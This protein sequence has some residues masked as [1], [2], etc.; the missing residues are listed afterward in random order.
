MCN[1]G[2]PCGRTLLVLVLNVE[3]PDVRSSCWSPLCIIFWCYTVVFLVTKHKDIS[4]HTDWVIWILKSRNAFTFY[5]HSR[6]LVQMHYRFLVNAFTTF[7]SY[8]PLSP[9]QKF[10]PPPPPLRQHKSPCIQEM[11]NQ[12]RCLHILPRQNSE[13]QC[14]SQKKIVCWAPVAELWRSKAIIILQ[15]I[16][17]DDILTVI[18]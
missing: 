4:N 12:G 17:Y 15:L 2:C 16:R 1:V 5:L 6:V 9:S 14:S 8:R 3:L 13:P 18:T 10:S 7:Y 11:Q